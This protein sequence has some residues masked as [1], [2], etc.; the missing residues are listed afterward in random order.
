MK[1]LRKN[2]PLLLL[3][4]TPLLPMRG[5]AAS[6]ELEIGNGVT[7][8]EEQRYEEAY[9]YFTNFL[10]DNPGNQVGLYYRSQAA[11]GKNDKATALQDI[12]KAMTAKA[13]LMKKKEIKKDELLTQRGTVYMELGQDDNAINDF[14]QALALNPNNVQAYVKRG[15][16]KAQKKELEASDND[17]RKALEME[18][19]N[20]EANL[21]LAENMM[22]RNEYSAATQLLSKLNTLYPKNNSVYTLRG[23]AYQLMGK[24]RE[25]F[26]DAMDQVSF[27]EDYTKFMPLLTA[28]AIQCDTYS[29]PKI[30]NKVNSGNNLDLWLLVRAHIYEQFDRYDEAIADYNQLQESLGEEFAPV[31]AG[32]GE[33]YRKKGETAQAAKEYQRALELEETPEAYANWSALK[34]NENKLDSALLLINK[35]VNLSPNTAAYYYQRGKIREAMN[36]NDQARREY[37]MGLQAD[38]KSSTLLYAHGRMLKSNK[39]DGEA[40]WQKIGDYEKVVCPTGNRMPLALAQLGKNTEA[41]EWQNKV[42]A[43][44][45]TAANYYDAGLLYAVLNMQPKALEMFDNA[46]NQGYSDFGALKYEKE[47]KELSNTPEYAALMKKWNVADVKSVRKKVA[48]NDST[49]SN[50]PIIPCT[51]DGMMLTFTTSSDTAKIFT[52]SVM[53]VQMLLKYGYMQKHDIVSQRDRD[54]LDIMGLEPGT[55]VVLRTF[56]WGNKT[57][58]NVTATLV[59]DPLAP[60]LLTQGMLNE[61]DK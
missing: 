5:I 24:Y 20:I 28:R 17:Y 12:N 40:D 14:T 46:F 35:A 42:L 32:R 52:I 60:I 37:E 50:L 9:K 21:G 39:K 36:N 33:C 6:N 54:K 59:E 38:R 22:S 27:Q 41:V 4:L 3:A 58:K 57:L 56:K 10:N 18:E 29:L 34:Y 31:C 47:L 15:K 43:K 13:G 1:T 7:A 51:V 44:F 55:Q 8:I 61:I 11:L 19:T 53:D 45:P 26:D 49:N 48:R 30:S 23:D 16:A 2:I 25:A